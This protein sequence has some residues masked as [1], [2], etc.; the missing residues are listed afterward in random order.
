MWESL[1]RVRSSGSWYCDEEPCTNGDGGST[2][3]SETAL[4]EV[5]YDDVLLQV[6]RNDNARPRLFAAFI[7]FLLILATQ[8]KLQQ[9]QS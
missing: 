6:E 7:T 4:D 1:V 5:A 3:I 2:Y 9:K 8:S